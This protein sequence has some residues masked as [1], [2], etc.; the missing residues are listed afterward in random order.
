MAEGRVDSFG[1]GPR[2]Y[3]PGNLVRGNQLGTARGDCEGVGVG[4]WEGGKKLRMIIIALRASD[5][6]SCT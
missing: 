6:P 3:L 2:R 5:L 1:Q 4:G